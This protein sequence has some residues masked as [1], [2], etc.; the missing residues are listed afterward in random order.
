MGP[1]KSFD[2]QNIVLSELGGEDGI[3]YLKVI[4]KNHNGVYK[5]R[6]EPNTKQNDIPP[7]VILNPTNGGTPTLTFWQITP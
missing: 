5:Y 3:L 6:F 2:P 1:S 7:G 4:L